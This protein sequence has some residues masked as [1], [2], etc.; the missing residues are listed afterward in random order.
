MTT[1]DTTTLDPDL[2]AL[3]ARHGVVPTVDALLTEFEER[4]VTVSLIESVSILIAW[5][6]EVVIRETPIRRIVETHG[7]TATIALARAFA[8][9]VEGEHE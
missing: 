1:T 2:A 8:A 3:L 6:W 4:G 5:R 7:P 9:I